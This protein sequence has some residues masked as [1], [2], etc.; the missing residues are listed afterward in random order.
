MTWTVLLPDAFE[1]EFERLPETVQDVDTLNS[2]RQPNQFD[3]L[4]TS[5]NY[6]SSNIASATTIAA[7]AT[8][9]AIACYFMSRLG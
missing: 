6:T 7:A 1:R 4:D 9:S 8:R 2:K 5:N 3:A